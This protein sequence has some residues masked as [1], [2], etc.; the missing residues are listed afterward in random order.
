MHEFTDLAEG[1]GDIANEVVKGQAEPIVTKY[2]FMGF[3]LGLLTAWIL[4]KFF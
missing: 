2:T 4:C 1:L 3:A